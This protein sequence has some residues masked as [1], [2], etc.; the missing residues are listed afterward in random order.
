ML[1]KQERGHILESYLNVKVGGLQHW[2]SYTWMN[3]V[4]VHWCYFQLMAGRPPFSNII[5]NIMI[6]SNCKSE[7]T[8]YFTEIF[9]LAVLDVG[10]QFFYEQPPSSF[11]VDISMVSFL[12]NNAHIWIYLNCSS[13]FCIMLLGYARK[14]EFAAVT[15][16]NQAKYNFAAILDTAETELSNMSS[17]T[18]NF[19]QMVRELLPTGHN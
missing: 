5:T 8:V 4:A 1:L 15:L 12:S 19:I 10:F 13:C 17:N 11:S 16:C 18:R 7:P 14:L 2:V 3:P 6:L 9:L